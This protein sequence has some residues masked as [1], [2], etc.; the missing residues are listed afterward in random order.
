MK[1][2]N[3]FNFFLTFTLLLRLCEQNCY[4]QQLI[5]PSPLA[6][7]GSIGVPFSENWNQNLSS[8]TK[9][10]PT[11]VHLI[12]DASALTYNQVKSA[13]DQLNADFVDPNGI[14]TIIF[15]LATIGDK[16]QCSDG[17]TRHPNILYN[18]QLYKFKTVWPN[19]KYFNIWV[20]S[21]PDILGKVGT[22]P[23]NFQVINGVLIRTDYIA[24]QSALDLDDGLTIN[25]SEI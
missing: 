7:P 17:I 4:S 25:T 22:R 8:G 3:F 2:S 24:G 23:S 9:Y 20:L 21:N 10:I 5:C 14:H 16:G 12:G 1:K 15:V 11:V 6:A 19:E 13:I 18:D